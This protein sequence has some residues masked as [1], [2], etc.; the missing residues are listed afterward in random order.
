MNARAIVYMLAIITLLINNLKAGDKPLH[1]DSIYVLIRCDDIGMSHA[2]NGAAEQLFE[3]KIPVSVSVMFT[4]P[5]YQEAVDLLRRFP[6]VSVG[7][8]LTLNAEWKNYRW[9]PVLGWKSVPTLVDSNGY[10]HPSRTAFFAAKPAMPEIER[11]LRAQI[12]RALNSGIRIDYVDHHMGTA[13]QNDTLRSM[14]EKLASEYGLAVT[15][16]FGE[17]Y[18][19]VTY[20]APLGEKTDSL[21]AHMESLGP[22]LHLQVC[23]I[24]LDNPEL[25]AMED[26]NDFGLQNMSRH[27]RAELD[28]LRS[29]GFRAVIERRNIRLVTYRQLVNR[30]GLD[31]MHRPANLDY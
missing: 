9:G 14:V 27:R 2:V 19:N 15:Q 20:G 11:E 24:G 28:A 4:C 21:I 23:H 12:E 22:G 8:H 5:W 16:Y 29:P 6:D 30:L 26:L 17:S 13:V 10:F 7:V 3:S 25:E 18:S 1:P 31:R